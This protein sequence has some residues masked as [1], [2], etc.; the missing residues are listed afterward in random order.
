M[1]MSAQRS[2][3]RRG[4]YGTSTSF[5]ATPQAFREADDSR[6]KIDARTESGDRYLRNFVPTTAAQRCA[7]WAIIALGGLPLPSHGDLV[8]LASYPRSGNHFLRQMIEEATGMVTYSQYR[9]G[10]DADHHPEEPLHE[11]WVAPDGTPV[12]A[13]PHGCVRRGVGGRIVL[14]RRQTGPKTTQG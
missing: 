5:C 1:T 7:L 9:D 13:P 3:L 2:G 10:S 14:L 4:R 11:F 8:Y 12:F 6:R